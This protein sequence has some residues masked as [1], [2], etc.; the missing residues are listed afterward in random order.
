[1]ATTHHLKNPANMPLQKR[2]RE[3]DGTVSFYNRV[4]EQM[5]EK[6]ERNPARPFHQ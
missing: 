6:A 1:M 2:E 4:E 5:E 3:R